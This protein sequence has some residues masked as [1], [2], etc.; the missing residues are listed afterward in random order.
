[1]HVRPERDSGRGQPAQCT[2]PDAP[3]ASSARRPA[4]LRRARPTRRAGARRRLPPRGPSSSRSSS[5]KRYASPTSRPGRMPRIAMICSPSRSGRTAASSSCSASVGDARLELVVGDGEAVGLAA[6]AGG[7]IGAGEDVQPLEQVAGVA[8]VAA[9]GRV[10]PRALGVAEEAQVQLDEPRHR[11]DRSRC[12]SAA[13]AAASRASFAPTTSWWWKVTAPPGS[14][15]RVAGLPM[16]CSSAAR[17]STRSGA[18][19]AARASRARS[20]ARAR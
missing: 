8:H 14:I 18:A 13:R 11:R 19:S 6:V 17:R 16:S 1:M 7:D 10:G 2:R 5:R 3:R 15:L 4:T 20:P 9:H 12:R